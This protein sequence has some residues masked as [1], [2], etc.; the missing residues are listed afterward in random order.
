MLK[1]DFFRLAAKISKTWNYFLNR[2]AREEE[3]GVSIL[4]PRIIQSLRPPRKYD[5]YCT[6]A[7]RPEY[8][9]HGRIFKRTYKLSLFC[10][11]FLRILFYFLTRRKRTSNMNAK[12][13][14]KICLFMFL[15][16]VVMV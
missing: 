10:D 5:E 12:R 16:K 13:K 2:G 15:S 6:R 9:F 8:N 3:G 11:N 1:L 14:F 4:T 7:Q